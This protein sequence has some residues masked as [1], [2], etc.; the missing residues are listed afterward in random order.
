M[1]SILLEFHKEVWQ[2]FDP[3][4][5]IF[6]WNLISSLLIALFYFLIYEK[7]NVKSTLSLGSIRK[8]WLNSSSILDYKIYFINAVVKVLFFAP[9][10]AL[11]LV[12]SKF[13]IQYLYILY[14]S[15]KAISGGPLSYFI[16]TVLVF[17]WDD[18]TRFFHH[19]LLHKIPALWSIHKTHHSATVLTPITL[20]RIHPLESLMAAFRNAFSLGLSGGII[21]FI[22]KGKVDYTVILGINAFGF[23]FNFLSGNLRHSH[24]PISFGVLEHILISPKQHQIHHSN[25]IDHYDK[26]FG[27]GLAIWDKF[28]GTFLMSK[29]QKIET[30]GVHGRE[31]Q[32]L[33]AQLFPWRI[34]N[35][36]IALARLLDR[37]KFNRLNIVKPK[38]QKL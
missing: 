1:Q 3:G 6:Y 13:T 21:L 5:R 26:N 35:L 23:L 38:V 22:F 36:K 7:E 19:Y 18:F 28:F 2:W 4:S 16:A 14:P 12:M 32:T 25:T 11:T 8:Y 30:F 31:S 20:F 15:H 34:T 9:V 29:G 10:V 17:V 37:T 27:V 24:I 33:L